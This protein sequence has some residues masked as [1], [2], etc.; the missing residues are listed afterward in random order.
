MS[1]VSRYDRPGLLER[2]TDSTAFTVLFGISATIF[3]PFVLLGLTVLP[4]IVLG[5]A[6]ADL[7]DKLGLLLPYG[8]LIG[9]I[10]LFRAYRPSTSTAGYRTTLA[11]L[12]VGIVTAASLIVG[13]I[14]MDLGVDV[15]RVIAI[16][17]LSLPIIAALGRIARLRRL[18]AAAEGRV[19][20]SLPL[21]FLAVALGEALCAIAIGV[22][23][24]C[25]G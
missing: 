15:V 25:A 12:T 8:G 24:A 7:G 3:V 13:L 11:C 10:G 2:L 4:G 22:Q 18:R 21:I 14:G 16:V 9:Y 20:D 1:T 5:A 23:L 6:N 19:L 17:A